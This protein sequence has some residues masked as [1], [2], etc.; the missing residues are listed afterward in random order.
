[1]RT[2]RISLA[3]TA[4]L[5]VAL[6]GSTG[7]LQ[8]ST[9]TDDVAAT[10][11][12]QHR[13]LSAID[14]TE[15]EPDMDPGEQRLSSESLAQDATDAADLARGLHWITG[16]TVIDAPGVYRVQN[17]F[18]VTEMDGDGIVVRS[19]FV[20]LDLGGHTLT[21]PGNKIGRAVVV[22]NARHVLVANGRLETFG[23]GVALLGTDHSAV[24]FIRVRGGDEMAAPPEIPPQIG[25]LLVNSPHNMI[26]WNDVRDTNLGY[27]V[28]GAGSMKNLIA[29]NRAIAGDR[30]LL[31]ICYN[32]A[33]GEGDAGPTQDHV[34][35]NLLS[36]FATG[37]QTNTGAAHNTFT[38]NLIEYFVS[39]YED[40]NGT[41]V[42][43]HNVEI[44]LTQ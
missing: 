18:D 42:F 44:P 41:N 22:E 6:L 4:T 40:L 29:G 37:I 13:V 1:M 27:F 17:D 39:P 30:G 31:A 11:D 16:P 34:R 9:T 25:V 12:F 35:H 43:R 20:W 2:S 23:I 14:A 38:R 32:P 15:A 28:R 8:D 3:I 10:D 36:R 5:A 24:A 26:R 7:C 21:G 33:P 19:D